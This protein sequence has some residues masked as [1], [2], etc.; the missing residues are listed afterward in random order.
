MFALWKGIGG[1]VLD[2]EFFADITGASDTTLGLKEFLWQRITDPTPT[3]V[4]HPLHRIYFL[5]RAVVAQPFQA[6]QASFRSSTSEDTPFDLWQDASGVLGLA[7]CSEL[8][9]HE[10]SV[11]SDT[12]NSFAQRLV[13]NSFFSFTV[14]AEHIHTLRLAFAEAEF[15]SQLKSL[16]DVAWRHP[17]NQK[18]ALCEGAVP[19]EATQAEALVHVD[20]K[21]LASLLFDEAGQEILEL[22]MGAF[23][24][25]RSDGGAQA[26]FRAV[27]CSNDRNCRAVM[28]VPRGETNS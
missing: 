12:D 7:V 6:L 25:V 28:Q 19:T 1:S 14:P 18:W 4:L 22:A 21:L 13:S 8:F 5:D 11:A 27:F 3:E 16:M 10:L 23:D 17:G 26:A 15:K 2:S 20:T 24:K 9:A